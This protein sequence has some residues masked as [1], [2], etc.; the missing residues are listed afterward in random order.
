VSFLENHQSAIKNQHF[1]LAL[2]LLMA[3]VRADHADN[4]FALH[5]LARYTKSFY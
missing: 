4:I 3:R 1:P 2:A 5:D